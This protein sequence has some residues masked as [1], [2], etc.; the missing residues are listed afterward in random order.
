MAGKIYTTE[1]ASDTLPSD[2]PLHQRLLKPYVLAQ[3]FLTG[4]E[5]VLEVGCGEGRG[6]DLLLPLS[7]RFTAIDK[8]KGAI[9]R[10]Q[11]KFPE[12]KICC[13]EFSAFC[14]SSR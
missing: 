7:D 1:V 14:G 11:I 6:I 10:L 5:S 2:N 13:P 4:K 3:S 12:G 8:L 9:A